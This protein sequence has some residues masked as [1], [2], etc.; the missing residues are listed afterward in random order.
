MAE[1]RSVL[2]LYEDH[3]IGVAAAISSAVDQVVRPLDLHRRVHRRWSRPKAVVV[4]H[5][6]GKEVVAIGTVVEVD[7]IEDLILHFNHFSLVVAIVP[8]LGVNLLFLLQLRQ[9]SL[10]RMTRGESVST[11]AATTACRRG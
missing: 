1:F 2:E 7:A 9:S 8:M 3:G 4:L 6:F 10:F 5:I 11:G